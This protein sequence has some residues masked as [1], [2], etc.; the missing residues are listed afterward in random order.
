MHALAGAFA[1]Y[2]GRVG[3]RRRRVRGAE[4][5][6]QLRT[7]GRRS[8][9]LSIPE[10]AALAHLPAERALPGLLRAGARSVT[11]PPGLPASGKPLGVGASGAPLPPAGRALSPHLLGPTGVG[12]STLIARLV[13]AISTPAAAP[14][15]STEATGRGDPRPHPRWTREQVDVSIR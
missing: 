7:L 1:A 10:L 14:S 4:R 5:K 13:L 3:L 8:Y 15:S 11:P 9:L 12:K 2:E 6:L